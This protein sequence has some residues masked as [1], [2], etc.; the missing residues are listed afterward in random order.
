MRI[1]LLVCL[2]F[3]LSSAI[4]QSK[5]KFHSQNYLGVLEG[6]EPSSFQV[7]SVNGF[8]RGTWFGGIGTGIDYYFFRSVPLFLSFSKYLTPKE[9]SI[10]FSVD[11]GTNFVWDKST[12]RDYNAFRSDGH[13]KPS[14]YFGGSAGYRIGLKNKRDAVLL[15]IG[16]SAKYMEETMTSTTFCIVPPCPYFTEKFNYHL[17][18]VSLKVGWQF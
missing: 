14:L 15:N 13:F 11:G 18:R 12:A 9:R 2:A 1:F 3:I 8:Q 17:S 5:Y 7:Q 6:N 16:Y 4:G 10:F